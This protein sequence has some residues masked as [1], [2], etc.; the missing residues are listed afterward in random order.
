MKEDYP[1]IGFILACSVGWLVQ[2]AY[3]I[4]LN[5]KIAPS[6]CFVAFLIQLVLLF[7]YRYKLLSTILIFHLLAITITVQIHLC[8]INAG[9]F[10]THNYIWFC[11]I[12]VYTTTLLGMKQGFIYTLT[13]GLVSIV[14][15]ELL[16]TNSINYNEFSKAQTYEIGLANLLTGPLSFYLMFGYYFYNKAQLLKKLKKE[17][18]DKN[19]LLTL[20][21]HDL[22]R[23][24]SLL[25]GYIELGEGKNLPLKS[26]NQIHKVSNQIKRTL[27][28][29]KKLDT[30]KI[31]TKEE[32]NIYIRELFIDL[33]NRFQLLAKKK[34]ISFV[35]QCPKNAYIKGNRQYLEIHI[36][37]NIISNAIKFS[38]ITNQIVLKYIID[39]KTIQVIDNGIGINKDFKSRLGTNQEEGSGVG[40]EIVR[41]YCKLSNYL[42]D[43]K[44][45]SPNGT[46][47]SIKTDK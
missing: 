31:K 38:N 43:F 37:D 42:L 22:G 44:Q 13:S 1:K 34:D 16:L 32:E 27:N 35:I 20:L 23:S 40:L 41:E 3:L 9:T 46:I 5:L 6:L 33:I 25:S 19:K 28:E 17:R 12:P 18:S 30:N 14:T 26:L 7:T 15:Q 29:A 24:T 47:V 11:V 39:T 8:Y 21:F 4:S 2:I 36:L 10:H 45:N